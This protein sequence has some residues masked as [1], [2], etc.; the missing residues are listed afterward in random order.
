MMS[1]YEKNL[2]SYHEA[3]HALLGYLLPECD[4]VHK[5]SIIPRGQRRWLHIASAY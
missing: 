5:V 2:V 3:G 1:E 4:P